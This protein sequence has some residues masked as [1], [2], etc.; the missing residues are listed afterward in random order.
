M[1]NAA[2]D[3][4]WEALGKILEEH[5]PKKTVTQWKTAVLEEQPV[6]IEISFPLTS[7]FEWIEPQAEPLP[8][9]SEVRSGTPPLEQPNITKNSL[10]SSLKKRK[11]H[12]DVELDSAVKLFQGIQE[13]QNS[14]NIELAT[15]IG[16]LA[17]AQEGLQSV[18]STIDK[19][20]AAH[21]ESNRLQSEANRNITALLTE[22][23]LDRREY[24]AL[25]VV[26]MHNGSREKI[27]TEANP[28]E[29]LLEF[30]E[31]AELA[32]S[33]ANFLS[34]LKPLKIVLL[35]VPSKRG[36]LLAFCNLPNGAESDLVE[37]GDQIVSALN[38]VRFLVLRDKDN[39]TGIWDCVSDLEYYFFEP[40]KRGL[41][42]SRAH[43]ELKLNELKQERIE[44][45]KG[46]MVKRGQEV[47][48]TIG[49][50]Q[51][52]NL[53]YENKVS[54]INSAMNA[55]DLMEGLLGRVVGSKDSGDIIDPLEE[56]GC[57]EPHTRTRSLWASSKLFSTHIGPPYSCSRHYSSTDNTDSSSKETS[58]DSS[59]E[60]SGDEYELNIKENILTASLPFVQNFGWTKHALSAGAE[61]IGYAGVAH[62]MF[63][64]EG[65][66]LV[67][68]FC[69]SCNKKLAEQM[70]QQTENS[71]T[72][73][74]IHL[75]PSVFIQDAVEARL[76]MIT[77]YIDKWPQALGIQTL[78]PNVPASLANLLTLVDDICYYAGDRSIDFNWYSRRVALAGIYKM[79]EL[80]LIQDK[81]ED[82]QNTWR[83]L[84]RRI[85][86]VTHLHGYLHQSEEFSQVAKEAVTATFVTA[87]NILGLS[88]GSR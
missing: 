72:G 14:T 4:Q 51:L 13:R 58:S 5:G 1:G 62:G 19:A 36:L 25:P 82:Y 32:E 50:Q 70:K 44:E 24:L 55:F 65:A 75:K 68:Y 83:F 45:N 57:F 79:T 17:S 88:L 39:L 86:D 8:G 41:I 15:A 40:L 30:L 7:E 76:R 85:K 54:V 61:S 20:V 26:I 34:L 6:D 63:P 43:F 77:P 64:R 56:R 38:L 73:P 16:K 80:C 49:G 27:A 66:E 52:P 42:I 21:L 37:L 81:S 3:R 74:N 29:A 28:E 69:T 78:P 22:F 53:P 23:L 71:G 47:T 67:L 10:S 33:D 18:A 46:M 87:R 35:R 9:P 11:R 2:M 12:T 59:S 60:E 31:Q 84:D 48:I